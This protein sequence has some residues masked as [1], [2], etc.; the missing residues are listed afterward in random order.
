MRIQFA[1]ARTALYVKLGS[2]ARRPI[3][4]STQRGGRGYVQ[5]SSGSEG[6]GATYRHPVAVRW[7]GLLTDIQWVHTHNYI[8][9]RGGSE[10]LQASTQVHNVKSTCTSAE[11]M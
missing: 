5:P 6:G 11:H 8:Y 10:V 3:G 9:A 2:N 7:E 1:S 4:A